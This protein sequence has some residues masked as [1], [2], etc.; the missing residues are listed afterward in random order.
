MS[1]IQT[2]GLLLTLPNTLP[3]NKI[4]LQCLFLIT[5]KPGGWYQQTHTPLVVLQNGFNL[6][7][8]L[9]LPDQTNDFKKSFIILG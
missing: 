9:L 5:N 2:Q 6:S 4:Q 1:G 7:M 8:K 3:K